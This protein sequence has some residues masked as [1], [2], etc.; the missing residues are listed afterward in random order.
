M[1][2]KQILVMMVAVLV[3]CSEDTR[4]AAPK[5]APLASRSIIADTIVDKAI[6]KE[7]GKPISAFTEVDLEK[8]TVL[9]LHSTEITDAGLKDVA[10][11]QKLT[12]LVLSNT[13]KITDAGLKD[14]AKLQKLRYLSLSGTQITD[15]GLKEVVKLQKLEALW[16]SYTKITDEGLKELAKLQKLQELFLDGTKVTA[17]GVA[18]LKKAMPNCE[19]YWPSAN[20]PV[21]P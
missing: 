18:E 3:G 6:R 7:L 21:S 1:G 16:L 19:I 4:K 15:E 12:H 20:S 9:N 10:K 11:L 17:A 2:M 5:K 8:V 14:F 13:K